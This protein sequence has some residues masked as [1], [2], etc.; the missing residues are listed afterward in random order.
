MTDPAPERIRVHPGPLAGTL[1]VPGDKSLSHRAL[2]IGAIAGGPVGVTG[3]ARSGDVRSTADCLRTLGVHIELEAV[4]EGFAGTVRGPIEE[5][6]DVLD[7]GNSGTAMR[8][9]AGVVAG[10]AGLSVLTGDASLRRRPV[11]RVVQ[12]L[13]AMGAELHARGSDRFPPL[14]VRGGHLR[15]VRWESPVASAQVKS[16]L[17][18]AGLVGRVDVEVVSPLRS[19]D[20]TERLLAYLDGE[21]RV[22]ELDDGREQVVLVPGPLV[23]KDLEVLGDPSSAAFFM[24][25]A[26]CAGPDGGEGIELTDLCV[27]RTRTG[28]VAILR[29]MGADAQIEPD[30][31]VSG[32]PAGTVRVRPSALEGTT[33]AGAAVVDAIDELPVLGLAGAMSAGGLEVRDAA[34]LRVKESDRIAGTAATLRALGIE[35]EERPDG[36]SV[37]GGQRPGGGVVDP[38]GDHRLAM[39]AAIAGTLATAAVEVVGFGCVATSYPRFLDDVAALGGHVEVLEQGPDR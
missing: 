17:L 10:I 23:A 29:D 33:I 37:H 4:P 2:I 13:R 6:V 36:Y 15:P 35:V 19:R 22:E 32:E 27:N 12:P 14:V 31:L 28:A 11:D 5:P 34:E 24:V 16:A 26:A 30:G 18:F 38:H 1:R 25:A 3:L 20:H 9:L 39:T 21:V 7:C 8:L